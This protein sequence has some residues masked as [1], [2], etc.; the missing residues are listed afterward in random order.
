[1]DQLKN[2]CHRLSLRKP[3][4]KALS[5]LAD[6]V[7]C[8]AWHNK[9]ADALLHHVRTMCPS[10]A[11]FDRDFPSFCFALATGVGKTRLMGAF[12]AWLHLEHGLRNFFVLAPNL[13]IYQKLRTDF[14]PGTPKYVFRGIGE[15]ARRP[16]F[17]ITGDDFAENPYVRGGLGDTEE[18]VRINIFNI[19]KMTAR[20]ANSKLEKDDARRS[21]PRM[22]RL[23]EYLGTSYFEYL[24]E[25]KDLVLLMDESHRYRAEAGME[26]LNELS[27]RLGLELT[28]TPQ[29]EQGKRQPRRF[30]NIVYEYTLAEAIRDGFVKEPAVVTRQNFDPARSTPEELERIK[31]EDGLQVH[32]NTKVALA[33]YANDAG[34]PRVKPFILVIAGDIEHAHRLQT[35]LE[36]EQVYGGRYRGK[37]ITVHSRAKGGSEGEEIVRQLLTVEEPDNPVEIVIHVNML[38]EG[39]DVTNLYTIIPLRAAN[40]R[41]LVEQSIGRGLR[42]PYGRRTGCDAVDRLSIIAHDRFQEIVDNAGREDSIFRKGLVIGRDLPN[43]QQAAVSVPSLADM[44]LGGSQASVDDAPLVLTPQADAAEKPAVSQLAPQAAP[45]S[46]VEQAR[47]RAARLFVSER[48]KRIAALTLAEIKRRESCRSSAELQ[49]ENVQRHIRQAVAAALPREQAELMPQMGVP[50]LAEQ[51]REATRI[52]CELSIDIPRV[53]VMP[54]GDVRCY[55]DDFT[56]DCSGISLQPVD[57]EIL[58]RHLQSRREEHLRGEPVI[59][60]TQRPEDYLVCALMDYDDINYDEHADRLYDLSGQLV[61]HLRAYLPDEDAVANVLQYYQRTLAEN[62]HGQMRRHFHMEAARYAAHVSR[63]FTSLKPCNYTVEK[64]TRP[65]P[66]H[67]PLSDGEKSRI[68][69]M[70]FEGFSKSLFPLMR[71]DSNAERLFCIVLENDGQVLKWMRPAVNGF[72][73]RYTGGRAYTPDFVAQTAAEN[74]LCEVKRRSDLTDDDVRDKAAA[75]REWCR[76][77]SAH[78][79][80]NGGNPWRYLLIPHDII[81]ENMTLAGLANACTLNP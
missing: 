4:E 56:L 28:A 57:E 24:A 25:L 43:V 45:P 39:W 1:M 8:P 69:G 61:A 5:L 10:F 76:N 68:R 55:Y 63:G 58:I 46:L 77:A 70:L 13:T 60:A 62:I 79:Q 81:R 7:R 59:R 65:R 54:E 36:S 52:Y 66:F 31:L 41:T 64:G 19:D 14:T 30:G 50:S 22:R 6:I 32:E 33:T 16:P 17:I 29:V 34:T 49:D 75:A 67:A 74:W 12:I 27:P 15:F 11:S 18:N 72:Q 51:V 40:S 2:V 42:L 20:V 73:I 35:L 53:I 26:A 38:K 44:V 47:T 80:N 78:T 48:D 3:Q 9:D 71:F 37:V 21:L 23:S